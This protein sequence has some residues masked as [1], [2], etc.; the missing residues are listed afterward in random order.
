VRRLE[1]RRHS[2]RKAGGGSQLSQ[3]GVDLARRVGASIGPFER[4][5]TSV[6]PRARETAIAMGFAV[7]QELLTLVDEDAP[8][9]EFE[10]RRWWEAPQ[11]FVALAQIVRAGGPTLALGHAIVGLWRDLVIALPEGAS[12]LV[13]GHSGQIEVALVTCFREADHGAWG[14]P[15]ACCEGARL[16][17][18]GDPPRF[19]QCEILRA[20]AA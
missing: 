12:A 1:V 10:A 2:L 7:D 11:P 8:A 5:A 4:V 16:S 14:G 17:F 19:T 3:A 18:D 20:P 9:A 15:F 13:I 6:S